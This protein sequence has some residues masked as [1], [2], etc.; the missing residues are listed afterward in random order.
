MLGVNVAKYLE[1]RNLAGNMLIDDESR[2]IQ[3]MAR[4][5]TLTMDNPTYIDVGSQDGYKPPCPYTQVKQLDS[6][7]IAGHDAGLKMVSGQYE[8]ALVLV[9]RVLNDM[10]DPPYAYLQASGWTDTQSTT[11]TMWGREQQAYTA[12]CVW[13]SLEAY[14]THLPGTACVAYDAQGNITFDA[15]LGYVHHIATKSEV[16]NV[17][18]SDSFSVMVKD[19]S[20]L[21]LDTSKL[22]LR[23]MA[24]PRVAQWQGSGNYYRVGYR[25]FIP[26]LRVTNNIIYVDFTRWVAKDYTGS[27]AAIY[28]PT[29]SFSV[30]YIPGIRSD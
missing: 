18:G 26:R 17:T 8:Q 28:N 13:L 9:Y 21:N 1:I 12:Q 4:T 27:I 10:N 16:I 25:S 20:G 5:S 11:V 30:Y 19:I 15:A 7:Q 24:F 6:T 22:F 3:I 29:Y 2:A 14:N 23:M